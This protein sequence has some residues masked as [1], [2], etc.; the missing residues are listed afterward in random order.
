MKSMLMTTV[1]LAGAV[2]LTG[3]ESD[4]AATSQAML[5]GDSVNLGVVN[6]TCISGG[7]D[8]VCDGTIDPSVGSVVVDGQRI[9]FGSQE[10]RD[11]F[12]TMP[13]S[14]RQK[15]VQAQGEY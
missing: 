8:H 14:Q 4:E 7:G 13:D 11:Y 12:E 1:L 2:V 3:C 9:G 5:N 15:F 10:C 6:D